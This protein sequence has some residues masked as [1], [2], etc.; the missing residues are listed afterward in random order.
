MVFNEQT[1]RNFNSTIVQLIVF[2]TKFA[3]SS[4][5][6]FNS[7]IVQLIVVLKPYF[8]QNKLISILL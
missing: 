6:D 8:Y 2:N 3:P 1:K 7:T 5:M 4:I